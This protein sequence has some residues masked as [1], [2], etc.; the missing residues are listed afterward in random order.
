MQ[1]QCSD[2]KAMS[3]NRLQASCSFI[4]IRLSSTYFQFIHLE[5][6]LLPTRVGGEVGFDTH[7]NTGKKS[8]YTGSTLGCVGVVVPFLAHSRVLH[9]VR[10]KN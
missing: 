7:T 3:R 1:S 10:V 6:V 2:I 4:I 5:R 9:H 8:L